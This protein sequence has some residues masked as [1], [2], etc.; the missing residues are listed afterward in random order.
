[1]ENDNDEHDHDMCMS[2]EV[3]I[4]DLLVDP[5]SDPKSSEV[6][7]EVQEQILLQ[8]QIA[9]RESAMKSD[10]EQHPR[11]DMEEEGQNDQRKSSLYLTY[12]REDSSLIGTI[13]DNSDLVDDTSDEV[14]I[15]DLIV[16]QNETCGGPQGQNSNVV[17]AEV[18]ERILL[19]A[20]RL[21]QEH[22]AQ[23]LP[24][25]PRP[26]DHSDVENRHSA[27]SLHDSGYNDAASE[28]T[29]DSAGLGDLSDDV[30]IQDLLV[31]ASCPT[32][33]QGGEVS[34]GV[35]ALIL[36][37]AQSSHRTTPSEH[38]ERNDADRYD[39]LK[40]LKLGRRSAAVNEGKG[41]TASPQEV[42]KLDPVVT[43]GAKSD[44]KKS[45]QGWPDSM[46]LVQMKALMFPPGEKVSWTSCDGKK[47]KGDVDV[48]TGGSSALDPSESLSSLPGAFRVRG[49]SSQNFDE[50]EEDFDNL[51][52][53]SVWEV[54]GVSSDKEREDESGVGLGSKF[55][56]Q[57]WSMTM[58]I[59]AYKVDRDEGSGTEVYDGQVLEVEDIEKEKGLSRRRVCTMRLVCGTIV[60]VVL[61]IVSGVLG[62]SLSG[63]S[64]M[65]SPTRSPS[66]MPSSVPSSSRQPSSSIEPSLSP[67]MSPSRSAWI[68]RTRIT[69]EG[70]LLHLSPSYVVMGSMGS[71]DSVIVVLRQDTGEQVG[72]EVVANGYLLAQLSRDGRKLAVCTNVTVELF[73]YVNDSDRWDVVWRYSIGPRRDGAI[74]SISMS[75]DASVLAIM[76]SSEVESVITVVEPQ[77]NGTWIRRGRDFVLFGRGSML[78][79]GDGEHLLS[80]APFANGNGRMDTDVWTYVSVD[81]DWI[82]YKGRASLDYPAIPGAVTFT[83]SDNSGLV[84]IATREGLDFW[85]KRPD[86]D[87][88]F[89]LLEDVGWNEGNETQAG[90]LVDLFLVPNGSSL[91]LASMA[92]N[93]SIVSVE[94]FTFDESFER[95]VPRGAT[96]LHSI[97]NRN[98][99]LSI[100]VCLSDDSNT[101]GLGVRD[102]AKLDAIYFMR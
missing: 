24:N 68:A 42:E 102:T 65:R 56:S 76:T 11:Y 16:D 17:S 46:G 39:K 64:D 14:S 67:S 47:T 83:M 70:E 41:H 97:E 33:Q 61:S 71:S 60:L 36:Y 79:S 27:E 6:S 1:M 72:G 88:W 20:Q 13:C 19:E 93:S 3:S 55:V 43:V 38:C 99:T 21:R 28:S 69:R 94:V 9:R 77:V 98:D 89:D 51:L 53:E 52:S 30:S 5:S 48:E 29:T 2:D 40:A 74:S 44:T 80:A 92:P 91:A 26:G 32:Q 35:Q 85:K 62:F 63:T 86:L 25:A 23:N 31:E 8:A 66:S 73:E 50:I 58:S 96:I 10:K 7:V 75:S 45:K 84:V 87:Y 34:A 12:Q 100:H 101:V 78:L 37:E 22:V 15:I 90:W 4:M 54:N 59:F 81:Q 18:Q 49:I 95:L 57:L 82:K